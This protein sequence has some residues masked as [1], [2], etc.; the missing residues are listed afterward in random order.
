MNKRWISIFKKLFVTNAKEFLRDFRPL[1]SSVMMPALFLVIFGLVRIY[2]QKKGASEQGATIDGPD[3]FLFIMPALLALGLV[4]LS[5][6]GT[7]LALVTDKDKGVF[8][9]YLLIPM[10]LSA[11]MAAHV[12]VRLVVA[13]LQGGV[14]MVT[15][16]VFFGVPLK[17]NIFELA[18]IYAACAVAMITCGYALAG[19]VGSMPTA[20]A[21]F[22]VLSFY[23]MGFG[24]IFTDMRGIPIAKWLIY[25]TPASSVSDL[26][27]QIFL[28]RWAN[29]SIGA[30]LAILS[31]WVLIAYWVGI[32]KFR[33]QP[34]Q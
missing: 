13:M 26:L 30:N 29:L 33:F 21:I 9:Q 32:R 34:E 7:A 2:V 3:Y 19:L 31:G 25:T 16:V 22:G 28:G 5:L 27:R 12:A 17:G 6:F 4:N 20:N 10:P 15:A 14:L 24:Q 18:V 8:R 1:F 11:L 23:I